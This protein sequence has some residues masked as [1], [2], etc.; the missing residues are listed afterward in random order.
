MKFSLSDLALLRIKRQSTSLLIAGSAITLLTTTAATA[1]T[2]KV[3]YSGSVTAQNEYFAGPFEF[4]FI[5]PEEAEELTA[6]R[7]PEEDTKIEGTYTF[8]DLTNEVTSAQFQLI[9]PTQTTTEAFLPAEPVSDPEKIQDLINQDNFR[10]TFSTASATAAS[11][12]EDI[13]GF[14][15]FEGSSVSVDSQNFSYSTFFS[16][17]GIGN[18]ESRTIGTIDSFALENSEHP[19]EATTVPEPKA[20]LGILLLARACLAGG[21]KTQNRQS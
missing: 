20:L 5:T 13:E 6:L 21:Y 10:T 16:G 4:L 8:D 12:R 18:A 1:A 7:P 11:Y 14:T 19:E 2:F 3:N 15:S 17:L 9:T